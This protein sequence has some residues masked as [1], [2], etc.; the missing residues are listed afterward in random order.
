MHVGCLQRTLLYIWKSIDCR[1]HTT[2]QGIPKMG[3]ILGLGPSA[4]SAMH[5]VDKGWAMWY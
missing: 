3:M 2:I 1:Q 5:F 4:S